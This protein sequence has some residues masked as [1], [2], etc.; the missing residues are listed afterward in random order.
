MLKLD[1]I[2][3]FQ[4]INSNDGQRST[5]VSCSLESFYG[6]IRHWSDSDKES[7]FVLLL[8]RAVG[9]PDEDI[10]NYVSRFPLM[11]LLTFFHLDVFNSL[12]NKEENLNG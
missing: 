3:F 8:G 1:E 5:P 10:D 4:L 12:K 6:L 9:D 2:Y 11:K 7:C